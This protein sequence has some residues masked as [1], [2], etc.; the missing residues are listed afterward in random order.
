MKLV[1]IIGSGLIAACFATGTLYA[2][3]GPTAAEEAG[4]MQEL[5]DLIHE[6][7]TADTAASSAAVGSSCA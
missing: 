5:I 7:R 1:R 6:G 4:D 2:Q 3:D